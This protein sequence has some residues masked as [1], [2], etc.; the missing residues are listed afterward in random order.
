[1]P[2][3]AMQIRVTTVAYGDKYL[4]PA[5]EMPLWGLTLARLSWGDLTLEQRMG[6][7]SLAVI[8]CVGSRVFRTGGVFS[9]SVDLGSPQ[10]PEGSW[11]NN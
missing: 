1:M 11:K 6:F 5:Q 3:A 4:A 8:S 9:D 2:L 7:G 10:T